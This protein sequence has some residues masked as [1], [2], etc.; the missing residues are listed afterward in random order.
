MDKGNIEV[1]GPLGLSFNFSSFTRGLSTSQTG[2]I[3]HYSFVIMSFIILLI[4]AFQTFFF[5]INGIFSGAFFLLFFAYILFSINMKN[6][7]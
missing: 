3:Y 7:Y 5:D 4:G 2:F 6:S 1:F